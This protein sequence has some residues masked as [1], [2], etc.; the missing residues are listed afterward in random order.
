MPAYNA[1]EFIGDSIASVLSQSFEALELIVVDDGSTDR[2]R[3]LVPS[4]DRRVKLLSQKNGG[5]SKARNTALRVAA[6]E[7]VWHLDADD[8]LVPE[9]VS[10]AVFALSD[11]PQLG[12]VVGR[13]CIIDE[14][15]RRS[16]NDISLWPT[17]T[18][19]KE[20]LFGPMLQRTLF[21]PS[22]ALLRKSA[23]EQA[24]GWDESLW[25]AEDRDLWLR[26]LNVSEGLLF[27]DRN[28][29]QYREHGSNAT[30]N[31]DRIKLH[32]DLFEQK[33]FS[34]GGL[35][36][37]QFLHLRPYVS[38]LASLYMARQCRSGNQASRE[39]EFID[40]ALAQ[41]RCADVDSS[42]VSAILWEVAGTSSEASFRRALWPTA[43]REVAEFCWSN[44][45]AAVRNGRLLTAASRILEL[46]MKRPT[47]LLAKLARRLTKK[48]E[49]R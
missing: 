2:T 25:C 8:I 23:V 45:S 20:L 1:A 27:S 16:S 6:G 29:T 35:A 21:P 24:G 5:P 10:E 44:L 43:R 33:W 7:Y 48:G 15:G 22:A 17:G 40:C 26:V 28:W 3:E 32:S 13:W 31:I 12:G 34:E 11:L 4:G 14:S 18:W 41:L 46:L 39:Q 38:C 9:A 37:Q 42:A 36:G 30:L 49:K 19:Q 47:F